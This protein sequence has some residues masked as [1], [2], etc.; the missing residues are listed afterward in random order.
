MPDLPSN[1]VSAFEL[2]VA[3][4]H[5]IY[6]KRGTLLSV[7][8]IALA[9]S[10]S[11]VSIFMMDGFRDMLFDVIIED[12]PHVTVTP[13]EG[14]DYIY[15]YHSLSDRIWDIPGVVA[16]SASL[17]T[18]ATFTYKE[19]VEN[20]AM[21]GVDPEDFESIYHLEEYMIKG[22]LISVQSGKK[23]I[24]GK[25]LSERLKVKMG[26]TIYASFP[27]ARGTSLMVSGIFDPPV[28]WPEDLAI[29]SLETARSFL[30]E[31][32]VASNVDIR[33]GDIYQADAAARSLQDYGYKADSWQ[34]LYPE[35]LETLAIETFENNLIMLLILIIASF[36]V[37]SVMYLLV[38]EKTSEIG[39]LMAMGAKRQSIM[40]IFLIESGLLGLMGGAVGAVLGL[41]LSLYL[42]NLEFSMEAPGGQKITLPVV[43]SLE[44]F[45]V[46]IIAAI[47]LS[48]IAGSYPAYK[49]SRLDPTQAIN[50]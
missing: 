30:N 46:I 49:A 12:L 48:I 40:N 22:D 11:L 33:L 42:G 6:R 17:G 45:L 43:I 4:R 27:D 38:N 36:G 47:A 18:S 3:M 37:G 44:S 28:G 7:A 35:I 14:D 25:K 15:L 10:I 13:K 20:V 31:G 1:I 23:V 32:D 9:V 50:A 8:A 34:K 21:S 2:T 29:V 16:V 5:I 24:L 41:A 26:Q 39:M 19:N